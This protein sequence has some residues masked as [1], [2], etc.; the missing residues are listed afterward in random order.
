MKSHFSKEQKIK[1]IND[2]KTSKLSRVEFC[3]QSKITPSAFAN[4]IVR[5]GNKDTKLYHSSKLDLIDITPKI[6]QK[7]LPVRQPSI[8]ITTNSGTCLEFYL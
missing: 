6:I 5:F 3:R 2:W 4:W 1:F 7:P 8:V